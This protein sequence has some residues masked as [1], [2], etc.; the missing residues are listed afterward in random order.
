MTGG[1]EW[2]SVSEQVELR[3]ATHDDYEAVAAFT[4]DTWDEV[5][6]YIPEVY[7]DWLEG[8][9]RQTLVAD[10]GEAIAGIA[11]AVVL[12]PAEGWL[13]GMRVNP[14]F[15][16]SGVASALTR[17]L[18]AWTREQGATVARNMVF[19]WNQAGLGQSRAVGFEPVTE[20]R[21]LHPDPGDGRTDADAVTAEEPTAGIDGVQTDPETAWSYWTD[22][23][24]RE[25]LAGL[26]V[27]LDES[28]A[29]RELTPA[30][31]ARATTETALFV[32]H[33][34]G[35]ARALTYR[36]RTYERDTADGVETGCEYGVAAWADIDAAET[37]LRAIAA[38]ATAC[39][40]DRTRVLVPETARYI[41]D[42]AALRVD[43]ADHTDFVLAADLAGR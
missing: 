30:M 6:D 5:E 9:D 40:A 1:E 14:S 16:G 38:D 19:S 34:E 17:A 27:D 23:D 15:R 42:A 18:F 28:W 35:N 43:I 7:H 36:T 37:L 2:P 31:L 25:H 39:G 13:Q 29:V 41:S 21:W 8:D 24:A 4:R 22:S 12:S 10:A 33:E 32:V 26:A 20:F 11:Q 3:P